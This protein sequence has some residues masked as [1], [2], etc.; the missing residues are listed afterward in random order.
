MP[1]RRKGENNRVS[2]LP[3]DLLRHIIG[4]LPAKEAV[5]T[6]LLARRWRN[7]WKSATCLRIRGHYTKL[8]RFVPH[9]LHFRGDARIDTCE[10]RLSVICLTVLPSLNHWIR[11]VITCQ[12]QMLSL[13]V[14][15]PDWDPHL[16]DLPLVS[17]HL[18][19]LDLA[20]VTLKNSFFDFSGCPSLEHLELARCDFSGTET[21]R[22]E[23]LKHLSITFCA[24]SKSSSTVFRTPSL[25]SLRLDTHL[26]KAPVLESM[27]SLQQAFVR[28]LH[29]AY[30]KDKDEHDNK[31]VLLENLSEAENLAL[32]SESKSFIFER[33]LKQCPTLS[34]LKILLLNDP[35]CTAPDFW[36]LTCILN[37]SPVLEKLTLQLFP[38]EPKQKLVMRGSCNLMEFSYA[39]SKHLKI[40]NV[41]CKAIDVRILDVLKFLGTFNIRFSLDDVEVCPLSVS[42]SGRFLSR[43]VDGR[44]LFD[45]TPLGKMATEQC[46][47][48]L[49]STCAKIGCVVD[50]LVAATCEAGE[51][52]LW[53]SIRL[54]LHFA[55]LSHTFVPSDWAAWT[56]A[57]LMFDIMPPGKICKKAPAMDGSDSID[58][59][60]D[61]ILEHIIG[62]LP[63]PQAAQT[64]LLARRWRHLW[65]RAAGLHITCVD[66]YCEDQKCMNRSPHFV[67]DLLDHRGG[68]PLET[69]ELTFS[70]LDDDLSPNRWISQLLMC[71]VRILS[72]RNIWRVDFELDDLPLSSKHLTRLELD[73]IVL[74]NNFCDFWNCPSLEHLEMSTCYFWY[75]RKISSKFLKCLNII[76]CGFSGE[77]RTLFYVPSLVSLRL[78]GHLYRARVLESVP[79]LHESFV[80]VVHENADSGD[81]DDYSGYCDVDDCYS[82]HGV[83]DDNKCVLLEA[84]SE[85][86]NLT[87][88]SESRTFA[89]ERDL[90]QCPTFGKLKTLLL[91]E[92]WCVAPNFTALTCIL[93]HSPVLENLTLLLYSKGP[94]HK[95]EMIGRYHPVDRTAALSEHLKAINVKCEVVDEKVNK[96]LKFLF[97]FNICFIFK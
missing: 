8:Q 33:E 84:L 70:G 86:E 82:C 85:A 38:K 37:H 42:S 78:D 87:L 43:S 80:R 10:L 94:K 44:R 54:H 51:G 96:V 7:L 11:H 75:T 57:H 93:K 46:I 16:D 58:V 69:C 25:V 65:K 59:L 49:L 19:R 88:V 18:T 56:H 53:C 91:N 76:N 23:S 79:S 34:K 31:C 73:G 30:A 81:C 74:K 35:W 62:F 77:F 32:I 41:E 97:A 9:L 72:L 83:L 40:V 68:A 13:R 22:S 1:P 20:G 17:R 12:A 50:I 2:A 28:V 4:F 66:G 29:T 6:C 26:S 21:I 55:A 92:S 27:P 15:D 24:F 63:A 39:I 52:V 3:D 47:R 90:K 45:R 89:F 61:G 71:Q 95:V 48:P 60:P 64:C 36:A 5:R 67:D 14:R